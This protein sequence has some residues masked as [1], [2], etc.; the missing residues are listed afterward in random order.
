MRPQILKFVIPFDW[1]GP[2]LALVLDRI[3][4]PSHA[5][6]IPRSCG[7]SG[8][9]IADM[10]HSYGI[11]TW[12]HLVVKDAYRIS[13][14]QT[15]AALAQD[16]LQHAEIP[17]QS[18]LIDPSQSRQIALDQLSANL[19]T[20][21]RSKPQASIDLTAEPQGSHPPARIRS[22]E[23]EAKGSSEETLRTAENTQSL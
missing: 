6:L 23:R 17:I 13:M 4:G 2:L 22:R 1:I 9:E 5:F 3:G 14:R 11:N 10:L 12:G 15:Q 8:Q 20:V 7:K 16:L 19:K 18:G 21:I